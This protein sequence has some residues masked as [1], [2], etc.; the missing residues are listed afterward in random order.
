LQQ[1]GKIRGHPMQAVLIYV[2]SNRADLRR[3]IQNQERRGIAIARNWSSDGKVL[4]VV[5]RIGESVAEAQERL[6]VA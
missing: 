4:S 1:T 6:A 3:G 5:I 2:V